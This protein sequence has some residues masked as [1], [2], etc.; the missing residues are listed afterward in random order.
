MSNHIEANKE[1]IAKIVLMPGDPN[2]ATWL[3]ETY[4]KNVK[5]VN[6]YRGMLAYT[7]YTKKNNTKVTIMSSGMG[8]PSMGIYSYEL[9]GEYDVD[10]I[11]RIGTCGTY[12]EHINVG[13]IIVA[14]SSSTNSNYANQFRLEGGI[15]SPCADIDALYQAKR[16]CE[17]HK[18]N[19]YFGNILSSDNFYNDNKEMRGRWS[20]LN[21]LA[22]EMET[23][24]LYTN[25]ASF[26]KRA[27]TLLTVTDNLVKKQTPASKEERTSGLSTMAELAIEISE[28]L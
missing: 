13:D 22:V 17:K 15:Y 28:N 23:Y 24:S 2:R 16:L 6:N 14:T 5:L 12:Q 11:I 26:R 25:A 1:D 21:V 27:L 18:Y 4:L 7:G 3:A 19:A 10:I 8:I 20:K 9:F